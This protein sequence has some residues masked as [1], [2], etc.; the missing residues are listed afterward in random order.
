MTRTITSA[1]PS[2]VALRAIPSTISDHPCIDFVNSRFSD[3]TGTGEVYERLELDEWRRWFVRRLG[4]PD[5]PP[6]TAP[7]YRR[8]HSLRDALGK[9]LGQ[10][11]S[12]DRR[13][14]SKITRY[15][16]DSPQTWTLRRDGD[17]FALALRPVHPGWPAV[18]TAVAA[19]YAKLLA[20]GDI[21]RVRQ[22]ANPDC[23]FWFV[24]DTRN[25]SRRWC[26]VKIC[27]NMLKVREYRARQLTIRRISSGRSR[28]D[29]KSRK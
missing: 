25:A 28:R 20:T 10:G 2:V 24:D 6:P 3:H 14:L 4:E 9:L 8:L 12:P 23:S 11:V 1:Q 21:R 29:Q 16:G 18:I 22:C 19:S 17:R 15:L 13:S 7:V 5:P 27:G 26:D